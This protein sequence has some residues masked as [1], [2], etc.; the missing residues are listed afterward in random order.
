VDASGNLF[1]T[2]SS[3]ERIRKVDKATGIIT[4]LAGTGT[5]GFGGD[6]GPA[7]A[8]MMNLPYQPSVDSNGNVYFCDFNNHR[9]REI[10]TL[11]LGGLST[12]AW[13]VNQ[14]TFTSA[15]NIIGTAPFSNFSATGLP[16]GL[17]ASL[18]GSTITISGTPTAVGT[19][20]NVNLSVQDAVGNGANRT[21]TITIN[22]VPTLGTLS[23][24]SWT[25][26]VQGYYGSLPISGGTGTLTLVSQANVPPG[27]NPIVSGSYIFL[28]GI[29]STPGNYNNIQLTLRD[30][31]GATGSGTVSLTVTAPQP[32]SILT[33]AG[34]NYSGYS[35]DGGPANQARMNNPY[36]VAV[37]GS[38]NI[39]I[40]DWNNSRIREVVKATGNIITVAGTGTNGFSGD[41]GPASSA[42]V[43]YP[44]GVAVDSSGNVYIADSY[45][46]RIREIV[47]ATGNIITVAGN[48]AT[49]DSGDGGSATAAGIAN[50]QSVAV[51]ASGNLYIADMSTNRIREVVKA[52]GIISTIAGT[53]TAGFSGDGG[54]ATAAMLNNPYGVAVD[55][56]GNVYIADSYN[57]RVREVVQA[58]GNIITFAGTGISGYSGDGGPA[59]AAK[60]YNPRGV[61][62]DSNGN[63]FIADTFNSTIREV[64]A[65]NS[66]NIIT[67]A[68]TGTSGYSGDGGPATSA[69]LYWPYAVSFDSSGNLYI[70]DQLNNV[71]REVL[72]L[73]VPYLGPLAPTQW[74]VNQSGY[75]GTITVSTAVPSSGSFLTTSGMPPGLSAS[76]NVDAAGN[77]NSIV[78]TGTPTV[79]GT[80]STTLTIRGVSGA[81][82]SSRTYGITI[83]ATP[84]LGAL[85]QTQWTVG[86]TGYPA[87]IP[88]SG[89][90][91]ALT[92]VAQSSLPPGLSATLNGS[93]ISF[94]GTPTAAGTFNNA[95]LSV[96]DADG[97]VSSAT[98]S[99]TINAAPTMGSPSNTLWTANQSGVSTIPVLRGTVPY[100]NLIVTGLMPGLTATQSGGTITISGTPQYN[101]FFTAHVSLQDAAGATAS[102]AFFT[103]VA[104]P[105]ASF[106]V[107]N[108]P[109]AVTAGAS[110]SF[111]VTALDASL[112]QAPSYRGTVY[113][114]SSDPAAAF[115]PASY[116]FTAAD[117]GTHTFTF[118]LKTAGS[119]QLYASDPTAGI[120]GLGMP[121]TVSPA[122]LD[123]LTV[124]APAYSASYYGFNVSVTAKDVYNNTIPDYAG[125]GHLTS[126][127]GAATLPADY[128]Y[129]PGDRGSH[130]FSATL[131]TAGT[132]T[133]AVNDGAVSGAA[134]VQDV[135]YIPGLHFAVTPSVTTATAGAP[136]DV[137]LT[138]LDQDNHVAV[139]YVGTVSFSSTDHGM[140][141]AGPALPADYSFTAADAGVHIFAGG[142]RL[143]SAGNQTLSVVDTSTVV[144][145]GYGLS[146]A[147]IVVSPAAASTFTIAGLPATV[148][149][150][151]AQSFTVTTKD[152]YGNTVTSYSGP[153]QFSSSDS[154]AILPPDAILTGGAGTFQVVF[155]SLGTQSLTVADASNS[156]VTATQ[157]G[158]TINP[159]PAVRLAVTGFP[160]STTAGA[161]GTF[162]VT[163]ID[164]NGYAATGYRGTVRFTSSDPLAVLPA[165]V[166]LTNGTGSFGAIF[167]T[168]GT[169]SLIGTDTAN[170]SLNGTESGITVSPAAATTLT[171]AGLPSS[172]TA[173]ATGS[174]T[175][176]SLDAYGNVATGYTGTVHFSATD[177][178]AVLPADYSFTA[179]D[180]G[181]HSFTIAFLTA[182]T[183]SLSVSDDTLNASQGG[184]V[185]NAA[186]VAR[187]TG[188][189]PANGVPNAGYPFFVWAVDAYGNQ[190][191]N[192][193][194]TVHFASSDA[195]AVL[196]A[197]YT[198]VGA[199]NGE[200]NFV[201]TFRT[202]GTQSITVTDTGAG[203]VTA[204]QFN[205]NVQVGA[206]AGLALTGFPSPT[207]A[208]VAGNFTVR[209]YDLYGNTATGYT[210]TVHFTSSDGAA[211]LPAD[212][213]FTAADV[214]LHTFSATLITAVG[215][216][217]WVQ[218]AQHNFTAAQ[219]AIGV[220][221]AAASQ[222]VATAYQAFTTA[223]AV[224]N[225]TI[226][227]KD[228]Y[229]NVAT[230]YRGTVHFTSSDVQ[231][232]VPANYTF[233]A[234]DAGVHTFA[235]TLK[236]AGSQT[237]S[238]QD[239]QASFGAT[240]NRSVTA[241]AASQLVLAGFPPPTTAGFTNS[242]T[243]RAYD[244][245]GNPAL[246]YLGT[247]HFTSSDVAATLPLDYTFT[248]G[249]AGVHTFSARLVTAGSQSLSVQDAQNNLTG[250]QSAI[251]VTPAAA[252]KL[253]TTAYDASTTAGVVEDIAIAAQ[254]PYGNVAT[255]FTGTVHVS[256]SDGKATLPGDYTYTPADAG[257]HLFTVVLK[258]AGGQTVTFQDA[259]HGFTTSASISVTAAAANR[260]VLS[261]FPA[262]TTAGAVQNLML[263]VRDAYG[264]I[265]TG[266][267]GMVDINSSDAQAVLP[268]DYT[269]SA[270]DN[271]VHTFSVC[272]R[273]AGTQS[274]TATDTATPSLTASQTGISVVAGAVSKFVVGGYPATTAGTSHSFTVSATDAY[275][276]VVTGY[277]GAVHFTTS[278]T[279]AG[280][281][282]N[283]T[284][285]AGDN[286]VHTFSATLKTAG[287]QS[288]T[289]SDTVSPGITGSQ[290]AIVVTAAAAT[291]LSITAPT[292]A[293]LSVPVTVTVT[294]LDAYGNIA[295]GYLGTVR[296]TSNDSKA[297][298]PSNYTFVA[299]DAG[300]HTFT[301]TF[302][303]SGTETLTATDTH[304]GSI[305]GSASVKVS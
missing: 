147:S 267:T 179:A 61:G 27:M 25:A 171:F 66:N 245:Y 28:Q 48:G 120:Y 15:V 96:Q 227:A 14:P 115:L 269:F 146:S 12:S 57:N 251:S 303:S 239:T 273:T 174:A 85:S 110:A 108:T 131:Q 32:G 204:F 299:T 87:T 105:A 216:G 114:N 262:T 52:T 182:A 200:H 218:D 43:F 247:V 248:A 129:T 39:F 62:V 214:G 148:T 118:T 242:F 102:G 266:Y 100:G 185:V 285:S 65:Y 134:S 265:A 149:R 20:S 190:I 90:T 264:N 259:Q 300:V 88:A 152:S 183:H 286:G 219:Y 125:T 36:S 208:G 63:V 70:A 8:A 225:V 24:S 284:F 282:G 99:I 124:V 177:A 229:G 101:G 29:P 201:V 121:I 233:T 206:A 112:I 195:Q 224:D 222:L 81:P 172:I 257:T 17:T 193:A 159:A 38:G 56:G 116:T 188:S 280:L 189:A 145:G 181:T 55:G 2:D 180:A 58:T 241:A 290:A 50:P 249:D 54:L 207:T 104:G 198:Y 119:Q 132:Q 154:Q 211:L 261:G 304:T 40:A 46:H 276:N 246:G 60:I 127:D 217:I 278:D 235:V 33:V 289:A 228:P 292:S 165:N 41:G 26:Q 263:T 18:S 135:D 4:T 296:F 30:A 47:K 305:K 293:S 59:T 213:T 231:A 3:N 113:F 130:A 77:Y 277:R 53:G 93:T 31:T 150:G 6:G 7:T 236:T 256:S 168:A 212:Y 44:T 255:S 71:I 250:G 72:P 221:P 67:V 253:V 254:D 42:Q 271:G 155:T 295:T 291:R 223:G 220:A 142:V 237:T 9:I 156:A 202:V 69:R 287:S 74:T 13:T 109:A 92:L 199:D 79:V 139:H 252:S 301:V 82:I 240:L 205:V 35:G 106:A 94:T 163:A 84:T 209:A 122:A 272:L 164:A 128:T 170:A 103:S 234:G 258:T 153:V 51:D 83:N 160:T 302:K 297:I 22:A 1:I 10:T 111:T 143:V 162:T 5:M 197:D 238:F 176:T 95:Q 268:A 23:P 298:L 73:P 45:N 157:G 137:T 275:G 136:F 196:P 97:A 274:L 175:V 117:A 186:A 98:Y 21:Y 203:G 138:A 187:L 173:G 64:Q 215:T 16:P 68:G 260:F 86:R 270:S 161:N 78:I 192:Y 107:I 133:I 158:I 281:P 166:T 19:Y 75:L 140:G 279:Q 151:V 178:Q 49:T 191:R 11:D 126:S 144:T 80:Y 167:K 288:L 34:T 37:D 141:G 91:G 226:A 210:G 123:H 89:G 76:P 244:A 194:S 169:K 283:Y 232:S 243:L 184:I 230:G 294:A